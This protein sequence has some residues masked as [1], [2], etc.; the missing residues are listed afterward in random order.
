MATGTVPVISA[1]A[2]APLSALE[3][4]IASFDIRISL[5]RPVPVARPERARSAFAC[6][7]QYERLLKPGGRVFLDACAYRT[8]FPFS[9]FI[10]TYIWSGNAT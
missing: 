6:L 7:Q 4:T 3:T 10:S 5:C 1:G 2:D 9:T 8:R